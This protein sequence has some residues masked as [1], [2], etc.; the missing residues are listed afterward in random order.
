MTE[1]EIVGI[2]EGKNMNCPRCEG[3]I[4]G[5]TG[6]GKDAP[7]EGDLTIC[8]DCAEACIFFIGEGGELKLK[9]PE[10]KRERLE[11]EVAIGALFDYA[12]RVMTEKDA[13]DFN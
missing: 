3:E 8:L 5:V 7:Q 6:K 11:C 4:K 12:S 10:T 2:R 9:L 1:V 13:K